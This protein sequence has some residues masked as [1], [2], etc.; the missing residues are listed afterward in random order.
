[1]FDE[2][3]SLPAPG[4][5]PADTPR[6]GCPRSERKVWEALRRGL[7]PGWHAWHSVR[8]RSARREEAEADFLLAVPG[9][10]VIVLEVK[11]GALEV[12]DG[13]WYQDGRQVAAPREQAHRYRRVLQ[14]VLAERGLRRVWIEIATCFPDVEFFEPP[15]QGDLRDASL[16]A[17][18]L[19]FLAEA[20][21]AFVER[22][23]RTPRGEPVGAPSGDAWLGALHELWGA[24]WVRARRLG[25]RHAL[26]QHELAPFN[27][28]QQA[29]LRSVARNRRMVVL[30][31]PGTG[32]TLLALEATRLLA[33]QEGAVG[34]VCFTRALAAAVGRAGVHASPVRELAADL[35]EGAGRPP[36]PG[37]SRDDWDG[38]VW[39]GV[40]ADAA[41][42]LARRDD[43]AP[44][45]LVVDEAQDLTVGDWRFV[46]ALCAGGALWVFADPEQA[47]WPDRMRFDAPPEGFAVIELGEGHRNPPDL[48]RFAAGYRSGAR[49]EGIAQ[50]REG[51]RVVRVAD[52]RA[53][54][55][56]AERCVRAALASG[57]AARDVAVLSLAG[58]G[59]T[60]LVEASV[61][62]GV[63]ARRADDPAADAHLVTDTFLRFKGLER[64]LV[65]LVELSLSPTEYDRRMYIA[66]T[67]ATLECVLVVTPAELAADPRLRAL[68]ASED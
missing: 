1:M 32:K 47:Y 3:S 46:R 49:P 19:D 34:F 38:A 15:A 59:R 60:A 54:P 44:L 27:A 17:R 8:V 23:F 42:L 68:P 10:G 14:E 51:A 4:V 62:G 40:S 50:V 16:G 39:D 12:R 45:A 35:L 6:P 55:E 37:I 29:V 30:G 41:E 13:C 48:A 25:E 33:A 2:P 58:R 5:H 31:G 18:D 66:L 61:F 64:A 56:A 21:Q 26:R 24:T 43:P 7:P 36:A 63:P 65:V 9:R 22:H 20:L 52:E 53:A 11:G 28:A 67:R 57:L